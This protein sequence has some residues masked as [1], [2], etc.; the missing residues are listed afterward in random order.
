MA[1][2]RGRDLF[3]FLF[4]LIAFVLGPF[5][6]FPKD[7]WLWILPIFPILCAGR[8]L[9]D[10]KWL[11]NSPISG[12]VALLIVWVFIGA[13]KHTNIALSTAKIAGLS[14]GILSFLA[15][16]AFAKSEKRIRLIAIMFLLG[17]MIVAGIGT[18]SRVE[19]FSIP[20]I[21][22]NKIVNMIPRVIIKFD[23]AETGI[24]PNPL[25]GALLLFIPLGM[26]IIGFLSKKG[27]EIGKQNYRYLFLSGMA[28]VLGVE[29]FALVY[30]RSLGAWLAFGFILLLIGEKRRIF[31]AC[32]GLAV[33]FA[34]FLF[35]KSPAIN[36]NIFIKNVRESFEAS[37]LSRLPVWNNG[38]DAVRDHPVFGL[39]LD[40]LRKTEPFSYKIEQVNYEYAHAHNQFI[41][42]A[43]EAGI[44]ALIAY[45]AILIGVWWMAIEVARSKM[46]EWM[47]LSMRGLGWGQI[48]FAIFGIADAITLGSKPGL[49]FWISLS[50]MTSIYL[51]G[52]ENKMITKMVKG[53]EANN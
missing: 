13:I 5:Y 14:Y 2:Y 34:C 30:S 42:L 4:L 20:Q 18:L 10:S 31:K 29:I 16:L 24:N 9:L 17:G 49:F 33:I 15:I 41:H 1:N 23:R 46:P 44:P 22:Q 8:W 51:Y 21:D 28:V 48:G 43:A 12:A 39:G 6:L 26:M 50:L 27:N 7:R 53:I 3:D 52:R 37:A 38:L 40:H 32:L 25:G 11:R 47:I 36:K 45:L 19:G 35:L